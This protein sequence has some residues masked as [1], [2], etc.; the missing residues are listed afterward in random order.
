MPIKHIKQ[1][2]HENVTL[3][4]KSAQKVLIFLTVFIINILESSSENHDSFR[5]YIGSYFE[6]LIVPFDCSFH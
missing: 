6:Y 4:V 2:N 5:F 3:L 1:I